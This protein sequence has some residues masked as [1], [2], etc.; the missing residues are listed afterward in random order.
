MLILSKRLHSIYLLRCFN[1][2]FAIGALFL[3]I[4]FYQ[5]RDWTFGTLAYTFGLSIKMNLLLVLPAVAIILYQAIG[6]S[7]AY[8]QA[9]VFMQLQVRQ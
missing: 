1:D 2:C 4:Y 7:R 6:P 5:R 3:C 8:R 9:L